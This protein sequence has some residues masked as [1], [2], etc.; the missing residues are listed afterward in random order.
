MS[1]DRP[2][3]TPADGS[4]GDAAIYLLGLLDEPQTERF[5]AHVETCAI[6]R[7]EVGALRPAVD[8]LPTTVPQ[9]AAPEQVKQRVMTA[10][11]AEARP[12]QADAQRP[13]GI[14]SR[15]R[16]AR[17]TRRPALA[18]AAAALL[19]GGAAI[20]AL[21]SEEHGAATRV[22]SANVTIAGASATLHES[23][24]QSWL[25]VAGL[26]RPRAGRV[27]EVWVKHAGGP[28]QPTSSLFSPTGAGMATAAVPSGLGVGSVVMVTQE[29]A[30]GSELPT[31]APVIVAR[32]T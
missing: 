23:G 26:P 17:G 27:Y 11:R 32:L 18:L 13:G 15:M 25:T 28:P 20:G 22:V 29:P 8:I 5:R 14:W 6:C 3:P 19:A 16:P 30:G 10:V 7:D 24:G 4:C 31:S 21:S 2:A 12:S 1:G 9:L